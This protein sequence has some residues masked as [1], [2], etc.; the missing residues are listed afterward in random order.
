[1]NMK[2][3]NFYAMDSFVFITIS[4]NVF[5][6]LYLNRISSV[7]SRLLSRSRYLFFFLLT[8]L[9]KSS[10]SLSFFPFHSSFRS[11]SFSLSFV[12]THTNKNTSTFALNSFFFFSFHS[13]PCH[14]HCFEMHLLIFFAIDLLHLPWHNQHSRG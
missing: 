8:T 3:T 9:F 2:T 4:H 1:M 6:F 14:C 12:L 7:I 13:M 5:L 10:V 11:L